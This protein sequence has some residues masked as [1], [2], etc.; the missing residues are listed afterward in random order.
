MSVVVL[1]ARRGGGWIGRRLSNFWSGINAVGIKELRGRMRGRRAFVVV[2]I[3]LALLS[4]L[5]FAVYVFMKQTGVLNGASVP[6]T[7]T[8]GGLRGIPF[9]GFDN[10]NGNV[11]TTGTALSAAI[12]HAMFGALLAVETLLVMVLAPA[13]TS[14]A[15]SLEREKQT[16]DLLVTT[17]LSTLGMV[18]GKL[19][20][21][22]SYVFLLIIASIPL[23]SLV[24]VF[25]AVGPED[26][27]RGYV[28]L[29]ALAFGMGALGLFIS[30]LTKRTQT[31]TVLTYVL[32][33]VLTIGTVALHQFWLVAARRTSNS[34][35]VVTTRPFNAPEA[36]LYLN[37]FVADA[38]LICTTAPGADH[39][40]EYMSQVTGKPYFGTPASNP[41]G[42]VDD[43]NFTTVAPDA[44][45]AGASGG[46]V[47]TGGVVV[48]VNQGGGVFVGP[49]GVPLPV[50]VPV[51]CA[52]NAKCVVNPPAQA[53]T[54][55][56]LG[57]PRDTFWP[58]S[59]AA[60]G[61]LGL[62]LTLL[63]AQLVAPTRRLRVR[64]P[65]LGW[66]RRSRPRVTEPEQVDAASGE[67]ETPAMETP[68]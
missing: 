45:F 49:D 11:T 23:A 26:L 63:A 3:Y 60:F 18:V 7:G 47:A 50:P 42:I 12:G 6:L 15:I 53:A 24:F 41:T 57:F 58:K 48:G 65:S 43:S 44:G 2:T 10:G 13:F 22:L 46:G 29:F 19:I 66:L 61:I 64:R 54:S 4:L 40:C 37:P 55:L 36:L 31:A 9:P 33:L 1:G 38:D 51:D 32:V 20:S 16:L 68:A 52:P 59:A 30:A 67:T 5:C 35:L 27:V 8:D 21:A 56:S 14:G 39:L 62:L 25:G 34:S 17:P 28:E